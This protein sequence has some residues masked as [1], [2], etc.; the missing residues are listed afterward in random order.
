MGNYLMNYDS[1]TGE[2]KGF[3][4]K[5]IHTNIPAPCLETT[6]E[7]HQFYMENNGKYKLN[8]ATLED[9]LMPIPEPVPQPPTA[10]ELLKKQVSDLENQ[11]LVLMGV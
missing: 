7:K 10:I 11:I 8:P 5:S 9:E 1:E 2:I 3:Y 6:S 4:L